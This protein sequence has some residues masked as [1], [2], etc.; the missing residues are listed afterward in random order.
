V[1][2]AHRSSH[3]SESVCVSTDVKWSES[4]VTTYRHL[5]PWPTI[6]QAISLPYHTLKATSLIGHRNMD[7]L[8]CHLS[9]YFET[10][11]YKL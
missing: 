1:S 7:Q 11:E 2:G 8:Y 6:R 4:E 9:T 3:T 5:A 10:E